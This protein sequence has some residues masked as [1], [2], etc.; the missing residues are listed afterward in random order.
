MTGSDFPGDHQRRVPGSGS[1]PVVGARGEGIGRNRGASPPPGSRRARNGQAKITLVNMNLLYINLGGRIDH[2]IHLPLGLLYL[3]SMLERKGRA[4]DFV[5]YQV[6]PRERPGQ[7]PFDLEQA[8]DYIG[9]TADIVGFS[10]MANLVPFTILVAER[11]KRRHPQK[12]IVL[13]GVGPFGVERLILERFPW[14]DVVAQGEAEASIELLVDALADRGEI[15]SVPGIFFR[16]DTGSVVRTSPPE[17]I[18]ELDA[19]P[20]PSYHRLEM[21][22]YDA[23]GIISSRGCPY[24][25]RFCSVAPIWDRTTTY[26]S[27]DHIIEEIRILHETYGVDLVLFQD[28]FFYSGEEKILDFCRRLR[29]SGL[30]VRWKCYGRVNLVTEKGMREMVKA[31]CVQIRFGVESASDRVL[32]RIVKG[33]RFRDALDA[34][35]RAAGIF[36]SVETFFMWG[37]PFEEMDDFFQ[38]AIQMARFDR[39]GVTVLPS[40]LS[41]LPQTE[42]YRDYLDGRYPGKLALVPELVPVYMVTGHEEVDSRNRVPERYRGH[43]DFIAAHPDIFPGFFLL[44]HERNALPKYQVLQEMGL[45]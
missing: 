22:H 14:I 12:T 8:L 13:G 4:V 10:C 15:A 17:R 42:I 32:E 21:A 27:H 20:L 30:P 35:T 7:D 41:M 25:C 39:M 37:F 40:L 44:D 45:L 23:F 3:M 26:R 11:L 16:S 18:R 9:D 33:F 6:F 34:V 19:L 2:E 29:E 24:G 43:Y 31:G 36:P 28:E 38:S 1:I 5:D